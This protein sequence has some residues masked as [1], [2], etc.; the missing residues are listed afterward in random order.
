MFSMYRKPIA[1]ILNYTIP[2]IRLPEC[3]ILLISAIV[4]ICFVTLF[5]I[6]FLGFS[7]VG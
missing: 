2:P 6:C 7:H 4:N 1:V 3:S 5:I